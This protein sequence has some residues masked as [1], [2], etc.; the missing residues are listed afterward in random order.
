MTL[1]G[2]DSGILL[3]LFFWLMG[4]SIFGLL[5]SI[6][7]SSKR[8]F[9]DGGYQPRSQNENIDSPGIETR[10]TITANMVAPTPPTGGS[11][12]SKKARY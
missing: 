10:P 4:C 9:A 8:Y 1:L 12:Q 7:F 3:L 6:L 2:I 5:L 11:G